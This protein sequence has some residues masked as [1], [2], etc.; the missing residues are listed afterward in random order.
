MLHATET[1]VAVWQHYARLMLYT[2]LEDGTFLA[3][4]IHISPLLALFLTRELQVK[5]YTT[6]T[7][8]Y[9]KLRGAAF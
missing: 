3:R 1:F 2:S 4:S 9:K 6:L 7:G 8:R 5:K